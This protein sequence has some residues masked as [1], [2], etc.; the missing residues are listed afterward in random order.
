MKLKSAIDK[1]FYD[2]TLKELQAINKNKSEQTI[3]YHNLLYL[4]IINYTKECTVSTLAKK[5]HIAKPAV[6]IRIKELEKLGLVEKKQ[7]K[8]DKRVYHL[9]VK[10]K[11][12]NS[13]KIPDKP[14]TNAMDEIKTKYSNEEIEKFS[15]M[16]TIFNKHVKDENSVD[17]KKIM[18]KL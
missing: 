12:A 9:S 2:V 14:Y 17:T 3:S 4:D 7:S 5:L 18:K 16:L 13:Y 15:E 11:V 8:I 1:L 10:P 6:T